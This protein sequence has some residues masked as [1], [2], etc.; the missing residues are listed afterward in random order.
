MLLR[1]PEPI[2]ERII[3]FIPSFEDLQNLS[4]VSSPLR[5]LVREYATRVWFRVGELVAEKGRA[6]ENAK[7]R[8]VKQ[9]FQ[10][11]FW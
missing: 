11:T 10:Q 8:R 5:F 3:G 9:T 4:S 7:M 2:L 1:L 6:N